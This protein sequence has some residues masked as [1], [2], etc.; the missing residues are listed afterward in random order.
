MGTSPAGWGSPAG[1]ATSLVPG[2]A[3]WFC[4]SPIEGFGDPRRGAP[5]AV[6]GL[7]QAAVRRAAGEYQGGAASFTVRQC[8]E[9]DSDV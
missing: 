5:A 7:D 2:A 3:R 1:G 4:G 6:G 8:G 9:A